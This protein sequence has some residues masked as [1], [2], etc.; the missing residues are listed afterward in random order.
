MDNKSLSIY[1]EAKSIA[2]CPKQNVPQKM[3]FMSVAGDVLKHQ[4]DVFQKSLDHDIIL[5]L[6]PTGTGKT[7]AAFTVLLREPNRHQNAIYIAP[8]NALVEQQKLAAENFVKS[9]NLPHF[10]IAASAKEVRQWSK[11]KVGSRPGEKI[12]NLLRNPATIFPE[13]GANRPV[14][15]VTNPDIFYYATFFE[16][17]RLDKINIASQF[18]QSFSTIIFDEFH[19]YDAKQLVSLLFYLALSHEFG[20]FKNGFRRIVLLTATPEAACEAAFENLERQGVRIARVNGGEITENLLPSQTSVKLELRSQPD[21]NQFLSELGSEVLRRFKDKPDHYGAIILDSLDQINRLSDFLKSKGLTDKVG[22]ITG[23]SPLIDRERAA[24]CPIILATSTV[25]VGFNFERSPASER[26]TLDWIIFSARDRA[27][28]WQ[29]LGR[30]GRVLGRKIIDL[31]S[32]AIAYLPEKAWEQNLETLD[33]NGGREALINKLSEIDC[34]ERPFLSIYWQSEAF[35]ELARPLLKLEELMQGLSENQ[36]ISKLYSTLQ[37]VLGGQRSWKYYQDRMQMLEAAEKIAYATGK[38]LNYYLSNFFKGKH[39]IIKKFLELECSDDWVDLNEGRATIAD[40][41]KAFKEQPEAA[42]ALKKFCEF[43]SASYAPIFNFR[44]SLF[45]SLK[46]KDY[47]GLMLDL[48]E[49]TAVDPIHLLRYYEFASSKDEIQLLDRAE[50]PYQI[51]FRLRFRGSK[52]DFSNYMNKLMA[53]EDCKIERRRDNAIY[54]TPLLKQ[55]EKK[56]IAGVIICPIKNSTVYYRIQKERIPIYPITV[57]GDDFEKEYAFLTGMAGILK[58][59]M[60]ERRLKL[61]D[62]DLF[63]IF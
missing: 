32:E 10:V 29:R 6:A 54:P 48:S 26:Q 20:Y 55:L 49:E 18:Y 38:N 21:R 19:L 7:K 16:Y 46:I 34:L 24:Q 59:A 11:D 25:D 23:P 27:A 53:F 60:Y 1:L 58:I 52:L 62:N 44:S 35:L 13:V 28:F 8:T 3:H 61:P 39:E 36:L 45:D 30:V 14:L 51:S 56:L 50:F 15:L 37:N 2:A 9:A 31:P 12:Y 41:A 17:N 47:D 42:N 4:V 43:Y 57:S 5:D 63:L 22:R 40:Y 33:I